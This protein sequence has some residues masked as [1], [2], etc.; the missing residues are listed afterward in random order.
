MNLSATKTIMTAASPHPLVVQKMGA[1]IL[2][3]FDFACL[4]TSLDKSG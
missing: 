1:F 3:I 4:Q 2:N